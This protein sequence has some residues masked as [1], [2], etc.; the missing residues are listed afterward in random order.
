[1]SM[2]TTLFETVVGNSYPVREGLRAL[3]GRWSPI[4]KVWR[5]P[6]DKLAEAQ[7][8]VDRGPVAP[9]PLTGY[10]MSL[11]PNAAVGVALGWSGGESV[12]YDE[13]VAGCAAIN[14]KP[15][16]PLSPASTLERAMAE[17]VG[18]QRL[19]RAYSTGQDGQRKRGRRAL[20]DETVT[21]RDLSYSVRLR[22]EI[23]KDGS[24]SIFDRYDALV[25]GPAHSQWEEAEKIIAKV[26]W[27][28]THLE[29]S[30][31]KSWL[32]ETVTTV[33]DG[34]LVLR[35]R[36]GIYYIPPTHTA[37]LKEIRDLVTAL[38]KIRCS[39]LSCVANDADTVSAILDGI[40]M[41]LTNAAAEAEAQCVEGAQ[42]RTFKKHTGN[43]T[44]L[45]AKLERYEALCQTSAMD[46]RAKLDAT[47]QHVAQAALGE[48]A[49]LFAGAA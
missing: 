21:G 4:L 35:E 34:V 6:A 18:R 23:T 9:A 27:Y 14:V 39:S 30:D 25:I 43:L 47:E 12:L 37:K 45:R 20:V 32:I 8:L 46:L 29:S 42:D 1:M 22:A 10:T 2:N 49:S 24:L 7:A 16:A 28:R 38:S 48:L 36:G 15:P 41:E 3:G 19:S 31:I 13:F 11:Q 33:L 40:G 26:E 5:V 17:L 44:A